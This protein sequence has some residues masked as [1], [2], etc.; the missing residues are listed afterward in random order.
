[1]PAAFGLDR[2][3]LGVPVTLVAV[4]SPEPVRRRMAEMGLRVGARVTVIQRTAG[5][6]RL[7]GVAG[8][9]IAVDRGTARA[10]AVSLPEAEAAEPAVAPSRTA[11]A[12]GPASPLGTVLQ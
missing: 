12:S 11:R 7:L 3:H 6:G 1:M 4:D 2:A 9:R 5:G 8:S 10:M